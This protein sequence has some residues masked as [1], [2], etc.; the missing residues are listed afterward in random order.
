MH[1]DLHADLHAY[2]RC[3]SAVQKNCGFHRTSSLNSNAADGLLHMESTHRKRNCR[4]QFIF[5]FV[6]VCVPSFSHH[7]I[8]GCERRRRRHESDFRESKE[9]EQ[10]KR[11]K[12]GREQQQ[13][14]RLRPETKGE[15]EQGC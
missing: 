1:A 4:L 6:K 15:G 13:Q 9:E 14:Q 8:T 10:F 12:E 11:E 5:G 3:T 2:W 7:Y